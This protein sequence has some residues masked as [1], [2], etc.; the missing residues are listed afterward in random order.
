MRSNGSTHVSRV[1]SHDGQ[2]VLVNDLLHLLDTS[3]VSQHVTDR[4]DV[5]VLDELLGNLLGRLDSTSSDRLSLSS[6]VF[7]SNFIGSPS[8]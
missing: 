8:Q 1:G 5:S 2:V 7:S 6:E 3:E 4:N